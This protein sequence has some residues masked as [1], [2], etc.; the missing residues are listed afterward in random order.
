MNVRTSIPNKQNV[1]IIL[2]DNLV[3]T[4]IPYLYKKSIKLY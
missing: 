3:H 4:E 1:I 2:L